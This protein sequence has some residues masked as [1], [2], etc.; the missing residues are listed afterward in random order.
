MLE[1]IYSK[2][3]EGKFTSDCSLWGKVVL[4]N[5]MGKWHSLELGPGQVSVLNI[6]NKSYFSNLS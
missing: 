4:M 1:A 6:S 3:I 5:V 2:D